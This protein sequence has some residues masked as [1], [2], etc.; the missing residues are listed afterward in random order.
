LRMET[1]T[2]EYVFP[3]FEVPLP[4]GSIWLPIITVNLIQPSGSR[5][6][7]PL[8]FDTGASITTLR[9]DLY[10]I[11]GAA[12]WDAGTPLQVSTAGGIAGVSAYQYQAKIEFLGKAV[13]CPVN[14]QVLP[15][16]PLYVGLLGRQQVFSEFGFGFWER[17]REIFV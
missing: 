17:T 1:K 14:L 8:L 12:S 7:L 3:F 6:A 5:I 16:N 2:F 15:R 13:D 11:L 9:D 4:T 10:Q